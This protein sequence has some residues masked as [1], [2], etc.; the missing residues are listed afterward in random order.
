[1]NGKRA[2][3]RMMWLGWLGAMLL[4]FAMAIPAARGQDSSTPDQGQ[5]STKSTPPDSQPWNL[6]IQSTVGTQ[7]HPSFPAEY[8]GLNSLKPGVEVKDTVSVDLMGGVRLWRGGEFFG[9]VVIWQGYGLSNTLGMAAESAVRAASPRS[10]GRFLIGRSDQRGRV[11]E[12][13]RESRRCSPDPRPTRDSTVPVHGTIPAL[14]RHG[15]L[16]RGPPCNGA[17]ANIRGPKGSPAR[18]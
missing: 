18:G 7:G 15:A 9:D 16:T 3:W 11:A 14:A 4:L 8:S 1:M 5:D 10:K 2:V 13:R 12:P 17:P 6:H